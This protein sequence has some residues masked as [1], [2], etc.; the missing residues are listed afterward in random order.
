MRPF[1]E[2][3]VFARGYNAAGPGDAMT[4]AAVRLGF[5]PFTMHPRG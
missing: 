1:H 5:Y 4:D 2:A 3:L